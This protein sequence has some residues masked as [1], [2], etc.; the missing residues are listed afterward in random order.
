VM[1]APLRRLMADELAT[2]YDGSREEWQLAEAMAADVLPESNL[3]EV[4]AILGIEW[5][6]S[7]YRGQS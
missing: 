6:P 5:K 4:M 1:S 2:A 7:V 3:S